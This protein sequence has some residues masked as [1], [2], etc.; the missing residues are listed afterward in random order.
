[1]SERAA[2]QAISRISLRGSPFQRG[3]Q[4]GQQARALVR[5]SVQAY[6]R[7]FAHHAQWDW[8]AVVRHAKTYQAATAEFAP[9]AVEEMRGIADGAGLGY[10]DILALNV[11]SEVMFASGAESSE[12][13]AAALANE[14]S[15][16]AVLPEA[17][18]DGHTLIGQNWDWL[19]HARGTVVLVDVRRDDGPDYLT[20]VEAGLLAKTGI[21]AVGVAVCTNTLVSVPGGEPGGVPYHVLLRKL[22]DCESITAATSAVINADKALSANYLLGAADGLAI[23]LEAVPGGVTAARALMPEHGVLVHANHFLSPDLARTDRWLGTSPG[24]LFRQYCLRSALDRATP[25][26]TVPTLQRMLSDHRNYPHSVCSHSDDGAAEY[27]RYATIA[28]IIYDLDTREVHLAPGA[29]CT[30]AYG[31]YQLD[32]PG[33]APEAPMADGV[34]AV[35]S[36]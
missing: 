30:A 13:L 34:Q 11:R 31:R 4:Y 12:R 3:Q 22:L 20:L 29:P 32:W 7:V 23:D 36:R 15:A 28:S 1:M 2:G 25:T 21:N 6:E 26:V 10:G 8:P 19:V 14:C 18:R 5:Q 27:E 9:S 33:G 24:T 16:F 17:T 35:M